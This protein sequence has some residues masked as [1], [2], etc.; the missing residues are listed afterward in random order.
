MNKLLV[1]FASGDLVVEAEKIPDTGTGSLIIRL[2]LSLVLI[3]GLIY[4]SLFLLKK[5]SLGLKKNR[6]GDLIQVLE[7]CYI[8]PKKGIFI[9]KIGSK[10]LA[11]GVTETQI[12]LLSEINLNPE[13]KTDLEN[14]I[15]SEK[16]IGTTFL[17]KIK[18]KLNL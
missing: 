6:A 10:L 12:N 11:L 7:R 18:G 17:Q 3:I 15:V 8:S 4:L 9:V 5:S 14:K 2:F 13:S 1:V 16:E